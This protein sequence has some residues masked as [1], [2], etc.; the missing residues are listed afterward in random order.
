MAL[1]IGPRPRVSAGWGRPSLGS[2]GAASICLHPVVTFQS[3]P[4]S[5]PKFTVKV[6]EASESLTGSLSICVLTFRLIF[7]RVLSS[8]M[9]SN[10]ENRVMWKRTS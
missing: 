5:C 9:V 1:A 2:Y 4:F 6:C 10:T 8:F 3:T 7:S